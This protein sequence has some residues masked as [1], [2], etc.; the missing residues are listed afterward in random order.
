MMFCSLAIVTY[1]YR[2]TIMSRKSEIH[3]RILH[4]LKQRTSFV[5]SLKPIHKRINTQL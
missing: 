2:N 1:T 3:Q 5:T 4:Q